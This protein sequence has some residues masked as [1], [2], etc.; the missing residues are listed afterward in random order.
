MGKGALEQADSGG[1]EKT[2]PEVSHVEYRRSNLSSIVKLSHQL[3]TFFSLV[4]EPTIQ[5]KLSLVLWIIPGVNKDL[6]IEDRKR[7]LYNSTM[8]PPSQ[9]W[10]QV[11]SSVPHSKLQLKRPMGINVSHF[12]AALVAEQLAHYVYVSEAVITEETFDEAVHTVW[13]SA[14]RPQPQLSRMT[15]LHASLVALSTY[16]EKSMKGQLHHQHTTLSASQI[17]WATKCY[18]SQ[19]KAYSGALRRHQGQETGTENGEDRLLEELLRQS[20]GHISQEFK[21]PEVKKIKSIMQI[22]KYRSNLPYLSILKE[23]C[24][25]LAQLKVCQLTPKLRHIVSL[26]CIIWVN[27]SHYNTSERISCLFCKMSNEIFCLCFQSISLDRI[28]KGYVISSN[29]DL[30][31]Y[32]TPVSLSPTQTISQS[33]HT[34]GSVTG[35]GERAEGRDDKM[36]KKNGEVNEGLLRDVDD[37]ELQRQQLHKVFSKGSVL[38]QPRI[39][40]LVDA[41]VQMIGDLLEEHDMKK[42]PFIGIQNCHDSRCFRRLTSFLRRRISSGGSEQEHC[43]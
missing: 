23:L 24:E 20:V 41:F 35:Q 18:T 8:T 13:Q 2:M 32:I 19:R 29:Q 12:M 43:H 25:E 36:R 28:F 31:D 1:L 11:E 21:K 26:I 10:Q 33:V 6:F 15:C 17:I 34:L 5:Q 42:R 22:S 16:W 38:D 27:S 37:Q 39:F 3:T 4:L 7:K 40:V 9:P 30:N 14:R